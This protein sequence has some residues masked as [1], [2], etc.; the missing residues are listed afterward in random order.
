VLLPGVYASCTGAT[1]TAQR[2]VAAVLY[3][4]PGSVITGP[5]ALVWHRIKVPRTSL[6]NVLVPEPRRRRDAGFVRLNRTSRMPGMVFPHGEVC[7]VPPA[8][9]VA[10]TVR[11]LRD[12]GTIRAIVADG[13]QRGVVPVRQ[14]ADELADGPAR[15]SARLRQ[16]LEEVADGVRSAA[17]ADLRALIKHERLPDPVYNARLYAGGDF[18]GAPDAWWAAAGVAVEVDSREWHLSPRDWERTLSRH[19][20]MSAHGIVVLHFPP[21]RLHTERR[22]AAGEIRSALAAGQNRPRL[23]IRALPAR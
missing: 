16:V 19:A 7:Y 2:E 1:T 21:R 22:T 4:G 17:E 10:D 13:V 11:G 5:S 18:I 6:V 20:R 9:A 15:G 14:L 8:R 12:L 23:D 3:A